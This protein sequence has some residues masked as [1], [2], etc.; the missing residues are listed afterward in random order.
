VRE[1]ETNPYVQ[2]V[3]KSDRAD[4]Q[5]SAFWRNS[6][7]RREFM[8]QMFHLLR[9]RVRRQRRIR[10]FS[11]ARRKR[12][13]AVL[14]RVVFLAWKEYRRVVMVGAQLQRWRQRRVK[15]AALDHWLRAYAH[16]SYAV[17]AAQ[18]LARGWALRRALGAFKR[19]KELALRNQALETRQS[20]VC[21]LFLS[22]RV[23]RAWTALGQAAG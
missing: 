3:V 9:S 10:A 12:S 18:Q 13:G 22:I 8:K 21:T 6:R 4:Q 20:L 2:G 5:A 7:L 14:K 16:Q 11:V 15:G 17:P 1:L 19:S 23:F